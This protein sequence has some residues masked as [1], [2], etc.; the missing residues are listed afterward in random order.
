MLYGKLALALVLGALSG[1]GVN[2][3][4]AAP[5]AAPA[6][7]ASC[8]VCMAEAKTGEIVAAARAWQSCQEQTARQQ[9]SDAARKAAP[10]AAQAAAF[11]GDCDEARAVVRAAKSMDASSQTLERALKSCQ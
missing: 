7:G 2:R 5:P 1:A 6:T 8:D 10:S 9:C 11:N 4:I 3:F